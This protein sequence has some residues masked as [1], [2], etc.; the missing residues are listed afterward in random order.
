[1][2][3]GVSAL[4]ILKPAQVSLV[5]CPLMAMGNSP[6]CLSADENLEIWM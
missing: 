3:L 5:L 4:N 6:T 2:Q 1:M